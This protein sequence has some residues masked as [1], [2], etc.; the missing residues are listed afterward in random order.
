MWL[1]RISLLNNNDMH[2]ESLVDKLPPLRSKMFN[3]N[4]RREREVNYLKI[5]YTYE[6]EWT[7]SNT[8]FP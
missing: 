4:N 2:V 3:G 7:V 1:I 8:L 5:K 6:V